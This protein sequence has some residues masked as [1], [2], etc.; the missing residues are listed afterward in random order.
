MLEVDNT[1]ETDLFE[2][3]F[4]SDCVNLLETHKKHKE[5]QIAKPK[6]KIEIA[7]KLIKKRV[8]LDK[9]HVIEGIK[10]EFE[11]N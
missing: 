9:W 2:N 1:L 7:M 4:L 8:D 11:N 3:G 5:I 10:N 6:S